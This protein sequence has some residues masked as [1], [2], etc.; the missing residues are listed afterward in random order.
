VTQA[1]SSDLVR[2]KMNLFSRGTLIA[3][4]ATAGM[5][6]RVKLNELKAAVSGR[7]CCATQSMVESHAHVAPEGLK[8]AAN[9]LDQLFSQS[10]N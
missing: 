9:R 1:R 3:M 6:P 7:R 2:G 5:A 4:P 10:A 8:Y